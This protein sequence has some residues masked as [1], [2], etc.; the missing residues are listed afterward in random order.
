MIAI[1]L[2]ICGASVSHGS[3]SM[4]SYPVGTPCYLGSGLGRPRVCN[5]PATCCRGGS[6]IYGAP[7]SAMYETGIVIVWCVNRIG[8]VACYIDVSRRHFIKIHFLSQ[9][10]IRKKLFILNRTV[11][12]IPQISGTFTISFAPR[13][14]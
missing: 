8:K 2:E 7:C 5:N 10:I 13:C 11:K 9:Y 4:L 1:Y 14:N 12:L 3:C 6:S